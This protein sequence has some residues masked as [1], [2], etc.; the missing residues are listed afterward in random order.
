MQALPRGLGV[1][2]WVEGCFLHSHRP[3]KL[4]HG[5][6]FESR[7]CSQIRLFFEN[8]VALFKALLL[9]RF[10]ESFLLHLHAN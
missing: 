5:A 2:E 7:R 6:T 4:T 1:S 10:I 8:A 3:L 9:F